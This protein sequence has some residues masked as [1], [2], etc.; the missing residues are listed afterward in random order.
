MSDNLPELRAPVIPTEPVNN[1][2]IGLNRA[3]NDEL[4]VTQTSD[5][6]LDRAKK[7]VSMATFASTSL[8]GGLI[9]MYADTPVI[10]NGGLAVAAVSFAKVGKDLIQEFK[11][12]GASEQV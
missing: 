5:S 1:I 11:P 10:S 6:W 9:H 4:S 2:T 7:H 3:E 8:I 12:G